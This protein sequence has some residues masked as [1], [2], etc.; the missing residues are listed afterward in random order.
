[1]QL[2]RKFKKIFAGSSSN[3]GVF[4]SAAALDPQTST[5]PAVIESLSAFTGGWEDATQTG[6]RLPTIE[7][8]N[9]LKYDTDYHLAYIYQDGLQNYNSLTTYYEDNFV[10]E[11]TT[12]KIWKSLVDDN[13]GNALTEDANWTLVGDL[14][15]LKEA[16]TTQI[17]TALLPKQVTISNNIAAPTSNLDFTTGNFTFDD[18]SG[19]GIIPFPIIKQFQF[20]FA[21]ANPSAPTGGM[22]N[23][24]SRPTNGTVYLYQISKADGTLGNIIGTTTADGSTI[25]TDPVVIANA[26]TKKRYFGAFYTDGSANIRNGRWLDSNKKFLYSTRIT[27]FSGSYTTTANQPISCPPNFIALLDITADINSNLDMRI[28]SNLLVNSG[29]DLRNNWAAGNWSG[30]FNNRSGELLVD[31]NSHIG[32]SVTTGG[33]GSIRTLGYIDTNI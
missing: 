6:N 11:E 8:L 33:S 27:D 4:G 30:G 3:I 22:V 31:N 20:T 14:A 1:M 32:F 7:D 15:Q 25:A 28:Y 10:R 12:G 2:L 18:G 23:G 17:G 21:L 13:T 24:E 19:Q 26:L 29:I 16:T 9:A 5:D